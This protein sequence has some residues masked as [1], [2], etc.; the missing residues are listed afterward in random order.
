MKKL[1]IQFLALLVAGSL[2]FQGCNWIDRDLNLDPNAPT[3]VNLRDLLPLIETASA[4]TKGGDLARFS[5]IPM[6]HMSGVNRQAFAFERY[7]IIE[8]DI[9]NLW[10]SSY[11]DILINAK[12][13]LEKADAQDAPYYAG[14]AKVLMAHRLGSM[15]AVWG[16]MP[17]SDALKGNEGNLTPAYDSQEQIYQAVGS[18]L[19]GAIADFSGGAGSV[20]VGADD[21]IF[22]G[23]AAAWKAAA[24]SMKA[25]FALHLSKRNGYAAVLAALGQGAIAD[26]GG[27]MY[28]NFGAAVTEWNPIYQFDIEREDIRIG[29][30]V[31]DMLKATGD[32]RLPVYCAQDANGDYTGSVVGSGN[33]DASL[34]GPGYSSPTAPV[35][36]ITY[37]E[38]KFIEAEAKLQTGDAAGAAAAYNDGQKASL[39]Q[40]GVSDAAWEAANASETAGSITLE[41]IINAKYLALFTDSEVWVDWRRTGF[42]AL[43]VAPNSETG[44]AIPRRFVYPLQ[45]RLYNGGNMPAGLDQLDPVWWDN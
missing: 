27:D 33:V 34:I 40:H 6:Q 44:G 18:L 25:R 3:D 7:R 15:T 39:A 38:T 43:T 14:I 30:Q 24:V 10:S 16:D 21:A 11:V 45:E 23:D 26:N 31:V 5:G 4:Y 32:P 29:A 12:I 19:D 8:N 35:Y 17:Y 28:F 36:F 42:P 9:N 2:F 20:A 1:S 13:L 22:G 37:A 41:K